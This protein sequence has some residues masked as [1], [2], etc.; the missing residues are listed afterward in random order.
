MRCGAVQRPGLVQRLTD[1]RLGLYS[2]Q[3]VLANF[4]TLGCQLRRN[5][6]VKRS[7]VQYNV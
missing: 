2:M 4:V 3:N 1:L 5:G 7:D 6:I